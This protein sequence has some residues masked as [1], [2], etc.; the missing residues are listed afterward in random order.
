MV[1]P[2][3]HERATCAR[4]HL[5]STRASQRPPVP[6]PGSLASVKI[7]VL[8]SG[9]REHAIVTSL[10][11]EGEHQLIVAPGNIGMSD[12]AERIRLDST[13]PDLVA[14]FARTEDVD[15]VVIG[16]EAPL[17]AGVADAVR[18][19]GIPVFGPS[20]AA[21]QLEG[22]KTFAKDIMQRAEVPTGRAQLC[23]DLDELVATID[24]FGAPYVVKADGL[25][26]G[27]GVIVTSDREAAIAHSQQWLA[28]GPLLVEE[29]LDGQEVSLFCLSDGDTVRAF[30][31][32]QDF[33]RL[34]DE[35]AGPNTGG[36]GAYTPVPFLNDRF[37]G[38]Q[39][40]MQQVIDE[41]AQPVVDTMR[42]AGTPFQGLL[43][44]GLIVTAAGI[45][46]IEFNARFG[47]PETQVV[48]E[49]LAEP[50]SALLLASANGTLDEHGPLE[51]NDNAAVT[52]VLASEGYP[53]SVITG[54]E[55]HGLDAAAE[56]G[57]RVL[58]AATDQ[59]P[60][61]ESLI[62]T[63]GRVLNVV[64]TGA[65]L[66]EARRGAYQALGH[67]ELE[68]G[69]IRSDIAQIGAATQDSM[70]ARDGALTSTEVFA[71]AAADQAASDIDPNPEAPATPAPKLSETPIAAATAESRGFNLNSVR[72]PQLDGWHHIY[73]GKVREVYE[74]D[75]DRDALLIIA[76]NRVSA[77]D[78][79]LEPE[80]PAKGAL[81]TRL[82][83]WWFDRLDVPN[84]LRE[85]AGWDAA[86]TDD[87]A[88][89]AMRVAKLDM[90]PVECVV[91]GYLTGSGLKEYQASGTVCGIE[92]P[93]GLND[94]DRLPEPIYTPAHKAPQGEHDENI[95]FERTVELIGEDAATALREL[96]L[97]IF[98]EA[99]AIA[100]ERGLILADT[101]FEFGR[102]PETGEIT[103]GD[104]VLTSDSSRY[105]D[106]HAYADESLPLAVRL[107]SFDKQIVRNWLT[108]NWDGTGT[109]PELPEEIVEQTRARYEEL[110]ERLGV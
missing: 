63:G 90:F 102:D 89:R 52:V 20:R 41:V 96:S 22:S 76:S 78:H 8:G 74:S 44:C 107:A 27:K 61:G 57:A 71:A 23:H 77:F 5:R 66:Q 64:A 42:E 4:P 108:E 85:T 84:H 18:A 86:L 99:S 29:F 68:G 47:D 72:H 36:M 104:E 37:G 79:L 43:Y 62:A 12:Q 65:T 97:R 13:Q 14:N 83:R 98:A 106:A 105:W 56:H 16:P 110:F 100:E 58:H 17:V 40:F 26:S 45:R 101:K 48:L 6:Q 33:K 32:A 25:A 88:A 28:S 35:D 87:I 34:L 94:G 2:F 109:P 10:A 73:S 11:N 51:L 55:L 9:A 59:G 92:L 46:V 31:P 95:S 21:A 3:D 54:R 91:R 39:A 50:L 7:L 60:D 1:G 30:P 67:I 75:D 93:E 49:R 15:L 38:E 70:L 80:I 82:S 81:L 24:E 19:K 103:L 53:E 69:Q